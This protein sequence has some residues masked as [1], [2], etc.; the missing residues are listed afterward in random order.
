[1]ILIIK[2]IS[3]IKISLTTK[4]SMISKGKFYE[5]NENTIEKYETVRNICHI[6]TIIYVY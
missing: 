4:G 2:I 1:M 3:I 5:S 6:G